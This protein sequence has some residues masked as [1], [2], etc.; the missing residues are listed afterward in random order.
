MQILAAT[1]LMAMERSRWNLLTLL[2]TSL[3]P[4]C[5]DRDACKQ[6]GGNVPLVSADARGGGRLCDKPTKRLEVDNYLQ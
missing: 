4:R 2:Q 6:K 3:R 1:D 5:T